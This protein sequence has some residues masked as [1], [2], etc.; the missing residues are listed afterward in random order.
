M[1][2]SVNN[3]LNEGMFDKA[4]SMWQGAKNGADVYDI[5]NNERRSPNYYG[6]QNG[7]GYQYKLANTLTDQILRQTDDPT[8]IGLLIKSLQDHI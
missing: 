7:E 4:K 1:K 3:V 8:I 6:G 5:N 2:E